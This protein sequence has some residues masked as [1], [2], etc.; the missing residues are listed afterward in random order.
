MTTNQIITLIIFVVTYVSLIAAYRWKLHFVVAACSVLLLW[1]GL[2]TIGVALRAV[3]WNVLMLYFGMLLLTETFIVSGAPALLAERLIREGTP[4]RWAILLVCTASSIISMVVENVAAVLIVTPI[5]L[6]VAK[7][8][9]ISLAPV[10]IG[11]A[12]SSNL[13]GAATM[14]GDPPSMLMAGALG[15]NFNDFFWHYGRPSVFFAVELGA[16]VSTFVLWF[17]F[18]KNDG[19]APPS[20]AQKLRSTVPGV[21][22]LLLIFGLVFSSVVIPDWEYASGTICVVIGAGAAFWWVG[23]HGASQFIRQVWK[24]DWGTGFFILGI[25][26]LVGSFSESGLIDRFVGSLATFSGQ[27]V[28]FAYSLLVWGSV[29]VSAL[30]DNVPFVAAMLPVCAG[31]AQRLGVPPELFSFGMMIG[32]SVGGNITPVGASANIV[33]M[34]IMRKSGHKVKFFEF[35]RIGL[36]FTFFAV[37]ASTLFA[38]ILHA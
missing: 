13:Q 27:R 11:V 17:V 2:M 38:W 34:G 30:V 33:A 23:H 31:L 5:A 20:E 3:N 18:R 36:P 15:M 8:L 37:V 22:L 1:P 26:I 19:K 35:V 32:A 28:F 16:V 4:A 25:F 6:A 29:I 14:I 7:R 9:K 12:L 24:L 10:M 21:L